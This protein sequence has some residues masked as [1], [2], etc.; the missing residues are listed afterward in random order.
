MGA[1]MGRANHKAPKRRP[2]GAR[3]PADPG[4]IALAGAASPKSS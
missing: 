2:V 3:V 1:G 4:R